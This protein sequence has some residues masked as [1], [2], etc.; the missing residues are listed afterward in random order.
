MIQKKL[1]KVTIYSDGACK[2]NPDGPGAYASI[3]QYVDDAGQMHEKE[4]CEGFENATNNRME[5]LGVINALKELKTSCEVEVVTDSNYV[6]K[7][8]NEHW[9]DSWIKNNFRIGTK[10]EVKNIDLWKELLELIKNHK[11]KWT[12]VKGHDGHPENSRC[13]HMASKKAE[14]LKN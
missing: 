1:K 2:G 10:N 8:F 6:V 9:I 14:S 11:M 12:W 5:L 4:L 7:A 3:I 13:D